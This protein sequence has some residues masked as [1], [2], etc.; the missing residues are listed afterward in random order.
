[1]SLKNIFIE[2]GTP[3]FLWGKTG[4]LY[5]FLNEYRKIAEKEHKMG[6]SGRKTEKNEVAVVDR[7]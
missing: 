1:M 7:T 4:V 5:F 6:L 2:Q 3:V